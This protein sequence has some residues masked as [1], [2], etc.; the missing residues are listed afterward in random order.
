MINARSSRRGAVAAAALAAGAL[1]LGGSTLAGQE[2]T[3]PIVQVKAKGSVPAVVSQLKKM[4]SQNGMT[5]M[6]EL[7]QGKALASTG[8]HVES[9]TIFVGNTEVGKELYGA[10]PGVGLVVPV[11]VNVYR[12]AQGETVVSYLSPSQLLKDYGN[13]QIAQAAQQLDAKLLQVVQ[14]LSA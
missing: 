14:M 2:S 3:G 5:V 1:M 8:L 11:R 10:D 12:N 13:S 9:E 4:I 7:H 6:G